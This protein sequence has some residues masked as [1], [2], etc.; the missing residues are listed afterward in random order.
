[1]ISELTSQYNMALSTE[2]FN[3]ED[4]EYKEDLLDAIEV[5]IQH[6]T[7]ADEYDAWMND[8]YPA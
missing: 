4:E 2:T 1:M 7:T 8:A 3:D 6:Y 5:L